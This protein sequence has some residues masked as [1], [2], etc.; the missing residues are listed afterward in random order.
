MRTG[1]RH[2]TEPDLSGRVR[3]GETR[4]SASLPSRRRWR[5]AASGQGDGTGPAAWSPP[6]AGAVA[7]GGFDEGAW[8]RRNTFGRAG[9]PWPVVSAPRG[10]G[11]DGSGRR[12][13]A[14]REATPGADSTRGGEAGAVPSARR[15]GFGRADS[16]GPIAVCIGGANKGVAPALGETSVIGGRSG[17]AA[18]SAPPARTRARPT[19]GK[20][21]LVCMS[22][23]AEDS[24]LRTAR[25]QARSL[26]SSESSLRA[27]PIRSISAGSSRHR[28]P[29]RRPAGRRVDRVRKRPAERLPGLTWME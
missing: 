11:D 16:P 19:P 4:S 12:K 20:A 6:C 8:G 14:G 24:P 26:S 3:P 23:S 13:G 29:P 10:A 22:S 21:C 2:G 17:S 1:T 25:P 5:T 18:P 7:E 28:P 27:G 15:N 9:G